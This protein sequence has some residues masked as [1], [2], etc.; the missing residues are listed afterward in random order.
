MTTVIK[1]VVDHGDFMEIMPEFAKNMLIGFAR[2]EGRTVGI[3]ANQPKELAGCLDINSSIK[4]ARFV[5]FCDAF[6]IPL[7]SFVD[8][9]GFL[10]GVSQEHQGPIALSPCPYMVIICLLTSILLPVLLSKG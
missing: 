6:S 1:K 5:R 3:M 10:P 8:V 7:I 9:P 4:S 2:M